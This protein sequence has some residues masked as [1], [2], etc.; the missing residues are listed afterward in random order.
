[1][2][3]ISFAVRGGDAI[4]ILGPNGAGKSTLL[5]T[6]LGVVPP[7]GGRIVFPRGQK[8]RLG[9]VPQGS[10]LDFA[11]PLS[12][13]Q[14]ALMGR[15]PQLGLIRRPGTVD[16]DIA[17][18]QLK[19]VGLEHVAEAP[20]RSLS[21]GQRQRV[22]V[23]RA[24]TAEPEVLILDEPT[25]EMDP[26]AEHNLLSLVQELVSSRDIAVVF[27]T[28]EISAAAGFAANVILLDAV[29]G[30][31]EVGPA[32]EMVTSERM[33]ALYGRPIDVRR[34][35]DRVLVWLSAQEGGVTLS[36]PPPAHEGTDAP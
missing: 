24:L 17:M 20:F 2:G 9:Y 35:D 23:A 3:G 4:G 34:E 19:A 5:K 14:V 21:G 27:V 13:L 15:T 25:S 31:F 12:V 1:M 7:L 22:L 28:H 32:A 11:Y 30:H 26:A 18:A 29:H 16:R 8:P 6:V 33:S 36:S 10:R